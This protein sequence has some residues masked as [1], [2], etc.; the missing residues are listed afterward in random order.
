[1]F[2]EKNNNNNNRTAE[3]ARL[4]DLKKKKK[5]KAPTELSTSSFAFSSPE[6]RTGMSDD[7]PCCHLVPFFV[8]FCFLFF[9]LAILSVVLP[10]PFCSFSR[11]PFSAAV[12]LLCFMLFWNLFSPVSFPSSFFVFMFLFLFV[13]LFFTHIKGSKERYL[14]GDYPENWQ[15][16]FLS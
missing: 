6:E 12:H 13:C 14:L 9:L 5:K 8:C 11:S 10:G 16:V 4:S 2:R 7:F 3:N 1:M 15:I